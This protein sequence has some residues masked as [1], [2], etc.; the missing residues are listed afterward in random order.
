MRAL[1]RAATES[2]RARPATS[3][4]TASTTIVTTRTR[5][6]G[7]TGRTMSMAVMTLSIPL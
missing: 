1:L 3:Q 2:A 5:A 7:C 6:V 4:T